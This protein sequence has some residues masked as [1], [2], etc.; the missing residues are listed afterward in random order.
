MRGTGRVGGSTLMPIPMASWEC[1]PTAN[2]TPK[3]NEVSSIGSSMS[4]FYRGRCKALLAVFAYED[5][6]AN[7]YES[8]KII[9][10]QKSFP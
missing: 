2:K 7:D 6:I 8:Q 9:P 3:A 4:Y 1:R 5:V 10:L